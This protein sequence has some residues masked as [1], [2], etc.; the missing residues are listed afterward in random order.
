M[1]GPFPTDLFLNDFSPLGLFP[2][3]FFPARTF[4][5]LLFPYQFFHRH[6]QTRIST[7][8]NFLKARLGLVSFDLVLV[9]FD[10]VWL[11]MVRF[12]SVRLG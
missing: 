3:S 6:F 12:D 4:Q 1:T 9:G 11:E 2:A 8:E 5:L 10:W 7:D